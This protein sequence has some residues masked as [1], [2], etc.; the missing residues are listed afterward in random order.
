M[1]EFVGMEWIETS[2]AK[3]GRST[4]LSF[5]DNRIGV[6]QDQR[7]CAG[8]DAVSVLPIAVT[9][10]DGRPPTSPSVRNKNIY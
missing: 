2:A 9:G 5:V 4:S 1:F 10:I 3:G 6:Q 7:F 8:W